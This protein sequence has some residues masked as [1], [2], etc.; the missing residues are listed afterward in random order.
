MA[1]KLL[2]YAVVKLNVVIILPDVVEGELV[3][4]VLMALDDSWVDETN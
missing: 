4:G 1:S 3:V 2:E